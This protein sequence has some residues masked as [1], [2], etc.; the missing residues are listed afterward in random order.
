VVILVSVWIQSGPADDNSGW[1]W[2]LYGIGWILLSGGLISYKARTIA[3]QGAVLL[4]ILFLT[5]AIGISEVLTRDGGYFSEQRLQQRQQ[6][7]RVAPVPSTATPVPSL[8]T[9]VIIPRCGEGWATIGTPPGKTVAW[10]VPVRA[11]SF[12]TAPGSTWQHVPPNTH[13]PNGSM[14]R[15]CTENSELV[16]QSMPLFWS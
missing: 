10:N 4:F 9:A 2:W 14:L 13:V 1:P 12:G 8:P 7:V 11:E 6:T 5:D 3:A 16:G 15:F